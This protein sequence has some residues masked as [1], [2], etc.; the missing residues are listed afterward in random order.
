MD[1]REIDELKARILKV[2]QAQSLEFYKA[3]KPKLDW[4]AIVV[5]VLMCGGSAGFAAYWALKHHG[6]H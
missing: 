3:N 4:K 5:A 6:L 1:Q 2:E